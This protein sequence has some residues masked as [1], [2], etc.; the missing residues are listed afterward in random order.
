MSKTASAILILVAAAVLWYGLWLLTNNGSAVTDVSAS[1]ALELGKKYLMFAT[2]L[3]GLLGIA[4]GGGLLV[5]EGANSERVM[6]IVTGLSVNLAGGAMVNGD[7][8]VSAAALVA[9]GL[10]GAGYILK[11]PLETRA[12]GG[13]E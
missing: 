13:F 4:I 12:E 3:A 8:L 9:V 11:K 10:V 6:T 2:S 7:R 5:K 1:A